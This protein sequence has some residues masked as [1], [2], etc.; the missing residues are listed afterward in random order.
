MSAVKGTRL[1]I[2]LFVCLYLAYGALLWISAASL[3]E[4]VATHFDG[5][6]TPNGWMSSRQYLTFSLLFGAGLPLF[7]VALSWALRFAPGGLNVPHREY[8]LAPERREVV[9]AGLLRDAWWFACL[10]IA[11]VAGM[12]CLFIRANVANP[13]HLSTS[14]VLGLAGFFFTGLILWIVLIF[15]RFQKV[16]E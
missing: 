16:S 15:R 2:L 1:P 8:W 6:G 4:R 3:P 5:H 11:F 13:A 10:V 9:F 14:T 12:H 7:I